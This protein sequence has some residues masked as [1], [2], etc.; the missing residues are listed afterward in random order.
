MGKNNKQINVK[1]TEEQK[2]IINSLIGP[3]GGTDSE[4]VRNIFLAW[5]SEKNIM[6]D[7][8]RKKVINKNG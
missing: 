3:M 6:S 2:E 5:L 8:I 4:V 1:F 7:I